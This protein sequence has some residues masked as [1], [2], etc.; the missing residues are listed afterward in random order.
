[1]SEYLD[2]VDSHDR[3][4]GKA[5]REEIHS[6]NMLH[7]GVHIFVF[8]SEGKLLVEKRDGTKDVYPN[9]YGCSVSEHLMSGESYLDAARRGFKEELGIENNELKE[10][11]KIEVRLPEAKGAKDL[12][13]NKFYE[14]RLDGEILNMHVS[15]KKGIEY[16]T[17]DEIK[18]AIKNKTMDFAPWFL[19]CFDWYL[20]N[21]AEEK[22]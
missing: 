5:A 21:A 10:L 13:I 7:R 6:S 14:A 16:F 8:N 22:R 4:I 1:M 15:E 9:Y 3:V 17:L 11:A 2:V 12:M 18:N 20:K 19:K